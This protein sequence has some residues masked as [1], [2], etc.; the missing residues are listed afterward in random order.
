[1]PLLCRPWH[2]GVPAVLASRS[3]CACRRCSGR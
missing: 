3:E 1:L 2:R